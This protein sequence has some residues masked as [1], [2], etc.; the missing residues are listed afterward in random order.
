MVAPFS[1]Y[2]TPRY[3]PGKLQAVIDKYDRGT[4]SQEKVDEHMTAAGYERNAEGKWSKDGQ[5]LQVPVFGPSFFG[6]LAPP[7]TQQLIDAGFDAVTEIDETWADRFLVGEHET[8]FFV[9]CGSNSEPL[10]TLKDLHSRNAKPLGEQIQNSIAGTRYVNREYDRIIEAME[11]IPPDPSQDSEYMDL[12][13]QA[14][15]IYLRDMPEIM[16][17]EELH[18]VAFNETYW[19][20]WPTSENPY[21]APYP[22][23]DSFNLVI[24]AIQPTQ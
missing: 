14:L 12:A 10:D 15:D 6:P 18:A 1:A 5:A 13:A 24:H 7:L 21:V 23:F 22:P 8:L 9:H 3:L 2:I 11:A 17:L 19:T 16:L 20:G 4:P